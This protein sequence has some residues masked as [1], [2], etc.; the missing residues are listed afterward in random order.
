MALDQTD[1][2]I[3]RSTIDHAIMLQAPLINAILS[4]TVP[5]QPDLLLRG[6]FQL[7]PS[8]TD[9]GGL[10]TDDHGF[11]RSAAT[12]LLLI[13]LDV[14]TLFSLQFTLLQHLGNDTAFSS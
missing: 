8:K 11:L 5:L 10:D 13:L 3:L 2:A 14:S 6:M 1:T 7:H 4:S 12:G 9:D